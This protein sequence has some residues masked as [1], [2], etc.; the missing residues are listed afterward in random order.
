MIEI[1]VNAERRQSTA[2]TLAA[3]LAELEFTPPYAVALNGQFVPRAYYAGQS[4]AAGDAVEVVSPVGG[5]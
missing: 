4:L 3:L 1:I 2:T 5:G